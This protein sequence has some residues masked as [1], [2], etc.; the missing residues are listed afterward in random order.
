MDCAT[1]P[2]RL[3]LDLASEG[4]INRDQ[5]KND[6]THCLQQTRSV[7]NLLGGW[8]KEDMSWSSGSD[9]NTRYSKDKQT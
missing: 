4:W 6:I 1:G 7:G 3:V 8:W 9:Y 2:A 5:T